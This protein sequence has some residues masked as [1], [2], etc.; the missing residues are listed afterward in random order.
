LG[1]FP[2]KTGIFPEFPRL[3]FALCLPLRI[4]Y[5]VDFRTVTFVFITLDPTHPARI[6]A[7]WF[8]HIFVLYS[9]L[10]IGYVVD[11]KTVR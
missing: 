10:L 6:P 9:P 11:T 5:V 1:H 3:G 4:G 8:R 2:A 7:P